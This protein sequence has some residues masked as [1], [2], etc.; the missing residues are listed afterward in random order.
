MRSA[1]CSRRMP[2]QAARSY[3]PHGAP[4]AAG[5][6]LD[7]AAVLTPQHKVEITMELLDRYGL[8]PDRGVA[9]GDSDA[10]VPLFEALPHT[11]AVNGS[12]NLTAVAAVAY[13]GWDLREAYGA[14]RRLLERS[15]DV[16]R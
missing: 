11:V 8:T 14:G 12:D 2:H 16:T 3:S 6:P 13:H 15:P 1:T 4:V 9:Y 7:P 5:L 10:D